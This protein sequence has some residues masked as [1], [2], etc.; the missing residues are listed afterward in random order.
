MDSSAFY[1]GFEVNYDEKTLEIFAYP[2][3][4]NET[5]MDV[6]AKAFESFEEVNL[7]LSSG[8]DSQFTLSVLRQLEK[9]INVYIFS[10]VWD[11]NVFNSADVLHAIRLCNKLGYSYTNI[12]IDYKHFLYTGQHLKICKEYKATSP[13]I[14]LQLKMIDLIE[15]K[16]IP[17]FLGG[18][19]PFLTF[20]FDDR[21]STI[22]GLSYQQFI[23]NSFLNYGLKNQRI[24]I[25][26]LF[27]VSAETNYLGFKQSLDTVK[28]HKI[29]VP[30]RS[31]G[32]GVT[33]PFRK[34]FYTD[35]VGDTL[36]P[37]LLKNTGFEM[38]KVHL[39]KESGIYNQY[40]LLFRY[41]LVNT[42]KNESW[43]NHDMYL[44]NF[45]TL[46]IDTIKQ[47]FEL[48]CKETPDLR[49]IEIYNFDL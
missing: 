4:N 46:H 45:S 7:C 11:D 48:F 16:S 31:S 19:I 24:V 43:Y 29:V 40:D 35:I 36:L 15:D 49:Y 18:D 21:T 8:I 47:E 2:P 28:K 44:L 34:L 27:R 42:L 1:K 12:E 26:D 33:Q 39:A 9:R 20:N 14:A 38:L 22:S 13:Q 10:F 3:A 17:V 6:W 25:K 30:S 37:P 23:T 41:P 5:L 32:T